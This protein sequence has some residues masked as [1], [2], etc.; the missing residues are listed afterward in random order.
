MKRAVLFVM[1][2]CL[3]APLV[4]GR[5]N[6]TP[7]VRYYVGNFTFIEGEPIDLEMT[8]HDAYDDVNDTSG[9]AYPG[10]T[11]TLTAEDLPA[12]LTLMQT[13][14]VDCNEPN[15][16][17]A[18]VDLAGTL[19]K[20]YYE[21]MFTL[22]DKAGNDDNAWLGIKVIAEDTTPPSIGCRRLF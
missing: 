1:T 8:M 18:T 22:T 11:V 7:E 20:G 3:L 10:N 19:S 6:H 4:F 12:G 13:Q 16:L 21:I 15:D 9:K 5:T 14:Y 17:C 2:I